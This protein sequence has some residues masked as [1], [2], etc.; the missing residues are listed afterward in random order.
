VITDLDEDFEQKA[1][2]EFNNLRKPVIDM[3]EENVDV[4]L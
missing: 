2:E 3:G 1:N 4:E